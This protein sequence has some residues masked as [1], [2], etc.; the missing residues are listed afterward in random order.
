M[1]GR[2]QMWSHWD[3]TKLINIGGTMNVIQA[4][5]SVGARGLV[6]TSTV[7][8]VFGGQEILNGDESLP[9]FPLH[10][11]VDAYSRTK[12][13]AEQLVLAADGKKTLR[14]ACTGHHLRTCAL[15]LAGVFGP[16]ERRHL[17]RITRLWPLFIFRFG[18]GHNLVQFSGIENVV[19]AH[20]KAS[21]A[22]LAKPEVVGGQAY[23]ISDGDPI[24][25]FEFFRPLMEALGHRVSYRNN[26][27]MFLVWFAA[28]FILFF[29]WLIHPIWNF[30]P[31]MTPAEIYSTAS[32]HY[33]SNSK[34]GRDFGYEAQNPNDLSQACRY[35]CSNRKNV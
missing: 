5:T 19:Q 20:V 29:H 25:P 34:A 7:N 16:K 24:N 15:R 17:P 6:Y 13:V 1:S 8:V 27:P 9:Y 18:Y 30:T 28:Y 2:E 23:F 3:K 26:V 22:L 14:T 12:S 21:M 33:F 31:I 32:S 11:Y 10:R 4:A 35:Y